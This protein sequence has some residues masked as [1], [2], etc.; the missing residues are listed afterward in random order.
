MKQAVMAKRQATRSTQTS[1]TRCEDVDAYIAAFPPDVQLALKQLRR[2]IRACAPKAE[3][4]ISYGIP[5][6]RYHGMLI[7]FAGFKNH[8]S[9]FPASKSILKIFSKELKPFEVSGA[10]TIRFTPD[11]PLP[12]ALVRKIVKTRMTQNEDRSA[13]KRPR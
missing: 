10:S 13:G 5:A 4:R 7:Y 12:A 11:H 8:C 2:T 9:L 6:Y 3:E 1:S